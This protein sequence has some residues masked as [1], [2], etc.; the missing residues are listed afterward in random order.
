MSHDKIQP[1]INEKDKI[2]SRIVQTD[3]ELV[4][5]ERPSGYSRSPTKSYPVI[6]LKMLCPGTFNPPQP[7]ECYSVCQISSLGSRCRSDPVRAPHFL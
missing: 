6:S 3:S 7:H 4:Y 5:L 2:Q 1:W